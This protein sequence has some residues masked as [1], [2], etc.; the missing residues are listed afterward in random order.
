MQLAF[1]WRS[2]YLS[3]Y[4]FALI[5]AACFIALTTAFMAQYF[6]DLKP[7]VLCVYERYPYVISGGVALI[8]LLGN[9]QKESH[10]IALLSICVLSFSAGFLLSLYHVGV[11][12]H[13]FSL[14][15]ACGGRDDLTGETVETL[16]QQLMG[17]P[18]V[19][20]DIVAWR[21]LGR[22]LTEFNA[23]FSFL[24]AGSCGWFIKKLYNRP[25][26]N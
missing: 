15:A 14:T 11:E 2:P 22:S 9:V 12:H 18:V 6:F 8:G 23:L 13:L 20:C 16:R 5:L 26:I 4:F 10:A 7:C 21:F 19:R 24:A 3:L 25:S 17:A 1:N